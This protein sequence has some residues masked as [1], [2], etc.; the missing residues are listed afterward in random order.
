MNIETISMD[1]EEALSQLRG[2]QARLKRSSR[3]RVNDHMRQEYETAIK[4]LREMG[5]GHAILDID[6]VIRDAP[7]DSKERPRLAIARA[8]I[9]QIYFRWSINN[10]VCVFE[11]TENRWS[12]SRE[13]AVS[14]RRVH[15][16]MQ[17]T[18]WSKGERVSMPIEGFSLVPLIP[19][20]IE[21][22]AKLENYHILWEVEEWSDTKIG[23]K[24]DRDPYLLRR[25]NSTLFSVVAEWDLTDLERSIMKHRIDK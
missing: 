11:D 19:A 2:Y 13:V 21:L 1:K 22:T 24:P 12:K 20:S 17:I 4:A 10:P 25:L 7:V 16:N 6:D 18:S 9:K 15:H 3:V 23:A 14:M 5:K 8:D